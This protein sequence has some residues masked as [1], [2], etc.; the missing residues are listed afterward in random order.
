MSSSAMHRGH[1]GTKLTYTLVRLGTRQGMTC[2]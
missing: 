1:D 2:R